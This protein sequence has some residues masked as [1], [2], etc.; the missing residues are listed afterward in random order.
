METTEEQPDLTKTPPKEPQAGSAAAEDSQLP[1]N[2]SSANV[3]TVAR[4]T[5]ASARSLKNSKV[6]KL[7]GQKKKHK[8]VTHTVV[9]K[10]KRRDLT[11]QKESV[12]LA[13]LN[14]LQRAVHALECKYIELINEVHDRKDSGTTDDTS[15]G[16]SGEAATNTTPS[17]NTAPTSTSSNRANIEPVQPNRNCRDATTQT[18][19]TQRSKFRDTGSQTVPEP[20]ESTNKATK[21]CTP[22]AT[23]EQDIMK[24]LAEMRDAD[25]R[26]NSGGQGV[27]S[28][29]EE[30]DATPEEDIVIASIPVKNRFT[31]LDC[32]SSANK[33]TEKSETERLKVVPNTKADAKFTTVRNSTTSKTKDKHEP[34]VDV[35]IVSSSIG[36]AMEARKMYKYKRVKLHLKLQKSLC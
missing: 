3:S 14:I 31:P 22:A 15:D 34:S 18:D 28:I 25:A 30:S 10:V 29:T 5:T 7:K 20:T 8:I 16:K 2:D 35:M 26:A 24:K 33:T 21:E 36:K 12:I 17:K 11:S 19:T 1:Q 9:S 13:T 27:V 6:A 32:T 4:D 23:T